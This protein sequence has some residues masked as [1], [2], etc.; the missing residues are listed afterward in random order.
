MKSMIIPGVFTKVTQFWIP[1][2]KKGMEELG[3]EVIAEDMPDFFKARSNIWLPHIEEK[4]AGDEEAIVVGYSSG[5]AAILR[6]LEEHKLKGV[7]LVGAHYT[8]GKNEREK[9]SGYFDNE[10]QWEKIRNNAGWIA[11]F[12]SSDDPYIPVEEFRFIRD[13]LGTDYH[14]FTDR[15]HFNNI[16]EFPELVDLIKES[17]KKSDRD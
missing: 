16:T 9:A 1:Y 10:W 7:V 12:A 15:G 17:L 2:V 14:E 11:Q 5:A 8:H 6:Y 13:S 3:L 4:L